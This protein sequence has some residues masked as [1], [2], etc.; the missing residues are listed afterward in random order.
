MPTD[1]RIWELSSLGERLEFLRQEFLRWKDAFNEERHVHDGTRMKVYDLQRR[2]DEIEKPA[3]FKTWGE[4]LRMEVVRLARLE[5]IEKAA[6]GIRSRVRAGAVLGD[7]IIDYSDLRD[8]CE[9][10]K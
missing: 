10:L 7:W 9:A 8:L 5:R 4:E 6:E 2:M 1:D 3:E